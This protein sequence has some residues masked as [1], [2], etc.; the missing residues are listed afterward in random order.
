MSKKK[1]KKKRQKLQT[2]ADWP[3]LTPAATAR[4]TKAFDAMRD[5]MRPEAF[6]KVLTK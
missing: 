4:A 6:A 1:F 5:T 2:Q 3:H